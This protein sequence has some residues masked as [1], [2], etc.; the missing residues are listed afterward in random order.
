MDLGAYCPSLS[1]GSTASNAIDIAGFWQLLKRREF[2]NGI[3]GAAPN[4]EIYDRVEAGN[5]ETE[6]EELEGKSLPA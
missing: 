5:T 4:I 3:D 1:K 2:E 6:R